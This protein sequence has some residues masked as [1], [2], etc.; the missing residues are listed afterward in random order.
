MHR[1]VG[2]SVAE[3]T[4]TRSRPSVL[5]VDDVDA[6]LVAL[7]ALLA[8]LDCEVVRA[9][10]GNQALG[11]LLKRE[12][13]VLLLDVQ[14]PEMDGYEVA[15][16]ARDNPRT[17]DVPI[18]FVTAM[19]ETESSLLR[20]YG[21]GA[22]DILFKPINP[23]VLHSK[24]RVFLELYLSRRT[25]GDEVAAHRKTAAELA[26]VNN[27]LRTVSRAKSDF[28]SMI[29]HELRTPLN[30][31]IGFSELLEQEIGGPLTDKQK[32]FVGN[33]RTS[34]RH[35]LNLINDI[36]DLSKIAAGKLE[37]R[38]EWIVVPSLVESVQSGVETLAGT[39]GVT[40]DVAIAADLPELCADPVRI[41]QI[42]YNLLS[43]GIKF[44]PRGGVVRLR[45]RAEGSELELV[46]EDTGIGIA[47]QDLPRLFREFE[48]L[49]PSG[50]APVQGT[51]LGLALT[52]RLV[53][54]HG[55]T[56]DVRSRIDHGTAFTIR[57]PT[58]REQP[59]PPQPEAPADKEAPAIAGVR[60]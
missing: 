47:P 11:H 6:N 5:L 48:Q 43:N 29:S 8:N 46:V 39:Q 55:G 18:I 23:H 1:T 13:A 59:K 38:R 22:V 45:A 36:L 3:Q 41:K 25:L 60:R 42:L 49:A 16:L 31:I 44:T 27:E 24:V 37:L 33:V 21:A 4:M 28:L 26:A 57:L 54:L 32:R 53:E 35:L 30:A 50:G 19:H 34:G 56:I 58:L 15:R 20:G 7:E 40:L 52:R 17:R 10:T 14:M 2:E 12:F 9:A 51:G